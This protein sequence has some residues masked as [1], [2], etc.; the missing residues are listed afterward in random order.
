M[1]RLRGVAHLLLFALPLAFLVVFYFYPLFV[2]LRISL[3]DGGQWRLEGIAETL[4]QPF[5]WQVLWFTTWQAAASTLLTVLI[6]L[7]LA[8]VFA[9]Y[10][11]RGKSILQALLTIPFVMPTVVVAA[12]FTTLLG[13]RGVVNQWL[14]TL[15]DLPAPPLQ[16]MRTVWII[17]LAHTFYNVSVVVRTVGAFWANLNPRLDEA[18]AV[19][20]A[21]PGR[22]FWAVTLPLLLPSI[23]AASLLV[24]LFCF[25]SFG[26]VL[27]LGGLQFA[28]LE[29]EIYRQAVSLF[30]LPVAAFLAL[31]QMALTFAIMA[32]YTRLQARASLPL[33]LRPRTPQER[34]SRTRRERMVVAMSVAVTLFVLLS[35][36]L[37][38][39][40]RSF[41][42]GGAGPTLTYY[43]EL[44]IDRRQSAFFVA[45]VF[46][47]RNSLLFALATMTLSLVLGL[48]SAYL[49]A[50][51]RSWQ[52]AILDPLFLLPLG[53][54]AV[55]LG[56]G[57]IISMGPLR[58]SLWLTP[59][60]HT[61]IASPFV[62]RTF[63]PALRSLDPR[64][65]ESAAVL[66]A[67]PV[68]VWWEI[69]APLLYPAV[70]VSAVFAFTISLGEFGATLLVSRPD[71]PTMPMVIYRALGQPGLLNY[72]QALA[73]S[74]ILMVVA[75]VAMLVIERFRIG[76]A[77]EF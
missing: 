77:S 41:T 55:T 44:A 54:S 57:Y 66:G 32:L 5:F 3:V 47:I 35:P 14:Q 31:V 76:G 72:G 71:Y 73:M 10:T 45:P 42:L 37:A 48:I 20:G 64:L 17:L 4:R 75:G 1:D 50:R 15:L 7:P 6:G 16:L 65:R 23:L 40:W 19:L 63:L 8:Y 39:V 46:A 70:L 49:L 59:I 69:D 22:R 36:L 67:S 30:N 13:E 43:E 52:T 61:L 29:V 24:F 68:R 60:A 62:V 33:E 9:H 26:V 27:I 25:T 18:A 21:T 58:T 56:F 34:P 11:F 51:P 28:T 12:A 2:I 74:T 38:L 53:T